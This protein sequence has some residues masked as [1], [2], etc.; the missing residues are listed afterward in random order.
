MPRK[1]INGGIDKLRR[2]VPRARGSSFDSHET[3]T[4]LETVDKRGDL[5]KTSTSIWFYMINICVDKLGTYATKA[6]RFR[7]GFEQS[8]TACRDE[9]DELLRR[10]GHPRAPTPDGCRWNVERCHG[11]VFVDGSFD[12]EPGAMQVSG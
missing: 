1:T 4:S 12:P 10:A 8:A 11:F 9:H 5:P 3:N 7:N 6:H 2:A